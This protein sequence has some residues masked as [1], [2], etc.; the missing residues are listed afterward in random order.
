MAS[1]DAI[2]LR[3]ANSADLAGAQWRPY[4]DQAPLTLDGGGSPAY[5]AEVF[6]QVR[7]AAG[8]PSEVATASILFDLA[9]DTDGDGLLDPID[10]DDDGDGLSDA[11]E[12]A[13][14]GTD[15]LD[16]DTDGDGV[17]DRMEVIGIG[18]DPLDP[19]DPQRAPLT[20]PLTLGLLTAG[21]AGVAVR[22]LRRRA[23]C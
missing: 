14:Y 21:L 20:A 16:P 5:V 19:T 23:R 1:A 12:L 13:L 10:D 9:A 2:E 6:V 7:N 17:G 18:S 8:V 22:R 3:A 4:V 15:P 11:D